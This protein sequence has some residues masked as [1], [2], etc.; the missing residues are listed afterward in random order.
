MLS[1]VLYWIK[2]HP[3]KWALIMICPIVLILYITTYKEKPAE[4][5]TTKDSVISLLKGLCASV[6]GV[7]YPPAGLF[8]WG[9]LAGAKIGKVVSGFFPKSGEGN[10]PMIDAK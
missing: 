8:V 3:L 9:K 1:R 7:L 6:A 5:W 4:N 2:K 10:K